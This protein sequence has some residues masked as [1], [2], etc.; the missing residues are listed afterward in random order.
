MRVGQWEGGCHCYLWLWW[1]MYMW[2]GWYVHPRCSQQSPLVILI[3]STI[4]HITITVDTITILLLKIL[5]HKQTQQ[6]QQ[7]RV[8]HRCQHQFDNLLV[9][10]RQP[11]LRN[12]LQQQKL[13]LQIHH[14]V[15]QQ[16]RVDHPLPP[17]I[18]H[19]PLSTWEMTYIS[20]G[21][22]GQWQQWIA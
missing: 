16:L 15:P 12:V 17:Q 4:H 22:E 8:H 13:V 20:P 7:Y 19:P 18:T 5:H 6:I 1:R 14:H 21:R 3:T 11:H 10:P 9:R 2:E